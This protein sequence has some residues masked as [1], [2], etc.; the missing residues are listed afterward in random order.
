M[1]LELGDQFHALWQEIAWAHQ[2]WAEFVELFGSDPTRVAALNAVAPAFFYMIQTVLWEDMLLH[3][4]RLTDPPASAG[5]KAKANL[6]VRN[7]VQLVA[8][9]IRPSTDEAVARAVRKTEFCRDWRNRHIAHRDLHLAMDPG[10]A[11]LKSANR[12]MVVEALESIAEVLNVV[13]LHYAQTTS[14]F[15]VT[16]NLGG[17]GSLLQALRRS[18]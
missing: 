14:F 4:A 9:E 6:T 18:R 7:L 5:N 15:Q 2:K 12:A 16:S 10:A 13:D 3:I 17:A 1:G 8:P 11:P